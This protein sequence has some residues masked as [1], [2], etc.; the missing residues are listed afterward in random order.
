MEERGGGV[1]A[2]CPDLASF[3]GVFVFV[4][5]CLFLLWNSI[6]KIH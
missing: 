2:T 6:V 1:F 3:S 5:F 4:L